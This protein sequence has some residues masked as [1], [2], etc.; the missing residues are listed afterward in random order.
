MPPRPWHA[1]WKLQDGVPVSEE[2]HRTIT[3]MILQMNRASA[4]LPTLQPLQLQR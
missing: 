2:L 4:T 3:S 1:G